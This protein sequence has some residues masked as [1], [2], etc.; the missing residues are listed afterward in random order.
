MVGFF[1]R[2]R[3][4]SG[5]DA[6]AREVLDAL[7]GAGVDHARY[8]RDRFA[9]EYHPAG[10]DEPAWMYLATV[11][12]ECQRDPGDRV[13]RIQHFVS[14][15]ASLT[16]VPERWADVRDLLR[17]VLRGATFARGGPTDADPVRRP[18]LPY[19]DELVVVDKP[20]SMAYVTDHSCARW[21]VS[22]EEVFAVARSNLAVRA[23]LP[24]TDASDGAVMI[25]FV[26]DGDA[27]WVSHL[28]LDRWLAEVGERIGAP[29]VAFAPDPA[30]LLVVAAEPDRLEPMF[31]L[32][33]EAFTE[34]PR[35]LSPM[36]YSV[37]PAGRVVPYT[38]PPGHPVGHLVGRAERL[39][40]RHEYTGQEAA[41]VEAASGESVGEYELYGR[42]DGSTFSVTTW[43]SGALLPRADFVSFAGLGRAPFFVPW[44]VVAE[45]EVVTEAF[46][47]RPSR[48]RAGP[49]PSAASLGY[50]REHAVQP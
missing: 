50:L 9:I 27:Y 16:G 31:D 22:A 30:S 13:H 4:R 36:G 1:D 18:S 42:P 8:H 11:Y 15:F 24:D 34:A 25:R 5:P 38:A 20:T 23:E 2:L 10:Q 3:R 14:T 26:D 47:H 41:L 6:F 28:L 48:Y 35:P 45:A 19:L 49:T 43:T 21:G 39:L 7:R 32:V 17:P 46:E 37:D 33:A 29:P 12:A 44:P 40:A